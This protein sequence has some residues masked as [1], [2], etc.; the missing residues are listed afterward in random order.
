M[1]PITLTDNQTFALIILLLFGLLALM[2][3]LNLTSSNRRR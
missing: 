3:F 2:A 1:L